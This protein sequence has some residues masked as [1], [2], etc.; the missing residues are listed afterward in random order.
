MSLRVPALVISLSV[1]SE[2][3]PERAPVKV[4]TI[5]HDCGVGSTTQCTPRIKQIWYMIYC[6][7]VSIN[8]RKLSYDQFLCSHTQVYES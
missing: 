5:E 3:Q 4:T 7:S 2:K 6:I 8:Q 1:A